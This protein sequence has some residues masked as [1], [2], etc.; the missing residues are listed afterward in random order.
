MAHDHIALRM[1][2][3]IMANVGTGR[4]FGEELKKHWRWTAEKDHE[5]VIIF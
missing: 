2:L 4:D 5:I 3:F 1:F